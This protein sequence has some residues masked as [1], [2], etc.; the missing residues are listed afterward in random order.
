MIGL[1]MD[2]A[3]VH[4]SANCYLSSPGQ[5]SIWGCFHGVGVLSSLAAFMIFYLC[6]CRLQLL[7]R[8]CFV[9]LYA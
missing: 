5:Q 7:A 4:I 8:V 1:C 3:T 9:V 6:W 2:S